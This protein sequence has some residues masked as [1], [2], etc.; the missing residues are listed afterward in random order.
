MAAKL[1]GIPGSH[2]TAIAEAMLRH[3]GI[4]YRRRDLIPAAHRL[5]LLRLLGFDGTSVPAL[6]IDGRRIVGSRTISRALDELKPDPLLFPAEPER[7]R[8][9]EDAERFGEDELQKY[10]R[11]V[12]WALLA[13]DTRAARSFLE[14]ARLGFPPGLAA[15]LMAPVVALMGRLNGVSE[16][17]VRSELRSLDADLDEV[18]RLI[19]A[20][21]IGGPERNAADFQIAAQLRILLCFDDLRPVVESHRAGKLAI[22]VYPHY[23]GHLPRV[24]S[25]D[26]RK[27]LAPPAHL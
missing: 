6:R 5:F 17:V 2:N 16:D 1:Y 26:E 22:A 4:E 3:K 21:V 27:L 7:R 8:A 13:R 11:H 25:P 24:L 15:P 10:A 23:P 20:G 14:G 12:V 18:D 19:D 9:V